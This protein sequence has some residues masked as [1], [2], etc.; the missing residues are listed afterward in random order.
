MGTLQPHEPHDFA[1]WVVL[2]DAITPNDPHPS[3]ATLAHGQW[4]IHP[5]EAKLDNSRA[6]IANARAASGKRIVTCPAEAGVYQ[7][8]YISLVG[9]TP[10]TINTSDPKNELLCRE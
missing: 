5:L 7:E 2:G 8:A 10:P 3:T 9:G 6:G 1:M 4:L